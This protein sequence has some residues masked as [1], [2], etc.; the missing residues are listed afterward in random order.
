MLAVG[1]LPQP[2]DDLRACL[3]WEWRRLHARRVGDAMG[4]CLHALAEAIRQAVAE[5][6]RGAP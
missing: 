4:R 6:D 1:S 3:Y 5:R 2:H